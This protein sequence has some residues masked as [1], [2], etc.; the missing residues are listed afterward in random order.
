MRIDAGFSAFFPLL[1]TLAS[2]VAFTPPASAQKRAAPPE[3]ESFTVTPEELAPGVELTFTVQGTPRAKASVRL[4]G[5]NRIVPLKEVSEGVYEG[6]YTVRRADRPMAGSPIR[7]TLS[8]R[9]LSAS[10]TIRVPWRVGLGPVAPAPAAPAPVVQGAPAITS[11]G[12]VPLGA[13]EPGAD[14]KFTLSGTPGATASFT[15]DGVVRDVPMREVRAGQYEGSYTIRR[16]DNFPGS[17]KILATLAAGGRATTAALN[18]PLIVDAK[19][20]VIK[21]MSPHNGETVASGNQLTVSA[22]FDDTGGV[23]VDPK[24][25]R[26]VVGGRDVTRN[27]TISPQFFN[28]RAD[29]P[30]GVYPVEVTARDLAG[31]AVLQTWRFSVAPQA[32][33]ATIL[34]LEVLSPANNAEVGSGSTEVRGRTAPDATVDVQVQAIASLA[35]LFGITQ[36]IL[37]QS[38]KADAAGN[39]SFSF[40]PKIPVPGTRY[41]ITMRATKADLAKD[42]KLVLFQKK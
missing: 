25:V 27:S 34:P 6:L 33:A 12:V 15:I 42:M 1:M 2:L 7:A 11:F 36:P 35:G 22:T 8:A 38:I 30:P 9:G 20:P 17:V 18:R 5:V 37:N 26:V 3:I 13:I 31:N 32:A 23:G 40:Q 29:L 4:G 39:F 16:L 24:S 10:D 19:P 41:E 14:L 21:N 28:F